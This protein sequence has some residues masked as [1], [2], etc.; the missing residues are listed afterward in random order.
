M[1]EI[2]ANTAAAYLVAT[3]R[4]PP[5][6]HLRVTELAGGVSNIVLKVDVEGQPPFVV[7]QCRERLRV[8][9]E[10]RA[11][12][13]R[14]WTECE[15]L[16]VLGEILPSG[17]VPGVLFEDQPNYLFAMECAP[18]AA[19]TW[20]SRLMQGDCDPVIA[21]TVGDLLG[22][23]HVRSQ[24][25]PTLQTTLADVSLFDELRIDPY[26]RTT[27][28]AVPAAAPALEA[29]IA[30]MPAIPRALVLGD[31][32]PKNILVHDHQIILLDFECAHAGD[33]AFDVGFCLSHLLLK[34]FR[35]RGRAA[36]L[37]VAQAF[38]DAYAKTAETDTRQ[39]A[40]H[41]AACLLARLDGKSPVEYRHELNQNS[42]RQLALDALTAAQPWTTSELVRAA[43]ASA[44]DQLHT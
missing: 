15:A 22:L 30:S 36:E 20:K 12:L 8:A 26:Y 40:R 39:A 32:S 44:S 18:Q 2:D 37:A 29:L 11:P 4:V 23:I 6:T 35:A 9:Q 17:S 38:L 5:A 28:R 34:L 7:K 14:I 31:Y 13:R 10:W 19:V 1:R 16:R 41:A 21:A 3:R 43:Q 42:I 25:H 27:A 24:R 33:P